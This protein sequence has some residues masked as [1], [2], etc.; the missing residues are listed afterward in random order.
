MKRRFNL[1]WGNLYVISNLGLRFKVNKFQG[2][3]VGFVKFSTS[4][5]ALFLR[6]HPGQSV[7]PPLSDSLVAAFLWPTSQPPML[8]LKWSTARL[9]MK[10]RS[11]CGL[12]SS[13]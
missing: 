12:L 8:T 4:K 6:Y 5:H 3:A 11:F 7:V 10:L 2:L 13:Q 9:I 1:V